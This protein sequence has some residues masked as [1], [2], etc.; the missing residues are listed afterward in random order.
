MHHDIELFSLLFGIE[1]EGEIK[2]TLWHRSGVSNVGS[3]LSV[4]TY[5]DLISMRLPAKTEDFSRGR[6][7]LR[8]QLSALRYQLSA[9]RYQL[10]TNTTIFF[11]AQYNELNGTHRTQ[12]FLKTPIG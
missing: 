2:N 4:A 12:F 3:V 1:M 9:L 10:Y 5:C 8:Y 6:S 7:A 11:L